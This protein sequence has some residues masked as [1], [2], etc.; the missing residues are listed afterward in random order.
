MPGR[1]R[2]ASL[3]RPTT[4]VIGLLGMLA[5][6][7]TAAAEKRPSSKVTT[8]K[9]AKVAPAKPPKTTPAKPTAKP[10]AKPA[11]KPVKQPTTVAPARSATSPAVVPVKP[12]PARGNSPTPAAA[13]TPATTKPAMAT[14]VQPGDRITKDNVEKIEGL[15]PPGVIW[16][17]RH[18]MDMNIVPYE[19]IYAPRAYVEATEQYSDQAWLDRNNVLRDW[20]AGMPFP[21]I[22]PDDPQVAAKIMNNYERRFQWTDDVNLASVDGETGA[23][24]IDDDGRF[25]YRIERHFVADW[26]RVLNFQGRIHHDPKPTISP[27]P[28]KVWRKFGFYPLS[29]PFDIKGVGSINYRY[30]DRER[31]DDTWFYI[32]A[33]R[34]VR[35]IS[36]AQRSD[37]LF[38]Q[39]IDVDSFGGYAGQIPWFDW[40]FLGEKPMLATF[41]GKNL[42][43]KPCE[44]N[45]G[46]TFCEDWEMRPKMFVIEGRP[47]LDSY[48]YSKRLIFVDK[49]TYTIP[50]TDLFDQNGELWKTLHQNIRYSKQPNPRV[51]YSY[52]EPQ[53][54]PYGITIID[55]QLMHATRFSLPGIDFPDEPGWYVNIGPDAEQAV[56]EDW[57]GIAALIRSG[58]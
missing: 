26:S 8:A 19:R 38:G 51:A 42:P 2:H 11:A 23:I 5:V 16:T 9:P 13:P 52:E 24:S 20:V 18:G 4:I 29:Q 12:G 56:E 40:K 22:D 34:R 25:R 53:M 44:G 47:K 49:E 55:I 35:R 21:V 45:D 57:Y 15:V 37:S 3:R 39:D 50:Y 41:H 6:I 43:G 46:V 31:F 7:G 27:N 54:F 1:A 36:A 10:V 14:Q 30:M 58:R 17:V 32:P 33:V 48:A 28:D